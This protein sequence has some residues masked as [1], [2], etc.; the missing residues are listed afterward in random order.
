VFERALRQAVDGNCI[1]Y[2][3]A[4]NRNGQLARS[5]AGG[6]SRRGSD[7]DVD[8]HP[9]KRMNIASVSKILTTVGAL[10][11][12]EKFGIPLA[13]PIAS[14]LPSQWD[15]DPSM[16]QITFEQLLT[17]KSGLGTNNASTSYV[18]LRDTMEKGAAAKQPPTFPMPS[19]DDHYDN[20][21]LA[22]FRILLPYIYD[23]QNLQ[24][25]EALGDA[26]MDV[27]TSTCYVS[28]MN[29][30]VFGP[31]GIPNAK[32]KP[33][34]NDEAKTLLYTFPATGAAGSDGGDWTKIGGGGGW[35]LSAYDLAKFL[36]YLGHSEVLLSSA[37]RTQM[38][39]KRYGW[40]QVSGSSGATYLH[41]YGTIAWNGG[42]MRGSIIKFPGGIEAVLLV[43]SHLVNP[44]VN[45]HPSRVLVAAYEK[46]MA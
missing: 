39:T 24:S 40:R 26:T 4:V 20:R 29:S 30:F 25:S 19:P 14:Y 3:F 12:L 46:A 36:A 35:V 45:D 43:N 28:I 2:A 8:Q 18:N 17:H 21:H 16:A 32:M 10:R 6:K 13:T 31:C 5:G 7:G 9:K 33:D 37:V 41:H 23:G 42:K 22:L 1:G 34:S 15:L 27:L 11:V 44:A 38:D